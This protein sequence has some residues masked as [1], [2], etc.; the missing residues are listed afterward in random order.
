MSGLT[1]SQQAYQAT[2]IQQASTLLGGLQVQGTQVPATA[3]PGASSA[4]VQA[5]GLAAQDA[6]IIDASIQGQSTPPPTPL[7]VPGQNQYQSALNV[8]TFNNTEALLGTLGLG[9]NAN[10]LA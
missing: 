3:P 6:G 10:S 8:S 9:T 2:E 7:E 4:E 5:I 1:S